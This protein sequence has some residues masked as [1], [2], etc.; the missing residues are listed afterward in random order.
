MLTNRR[1]I[2]A[3]PAVLASGALPGIARA[4]DTY[5]NRPVTVVV[6]FSAGGSTDL[7]A[8]L[9]AQ[10]LGDEMKQSF[11]VD[12]RAGA[13]GTLGHAMVARSK[14]DGY[15]LLLG[16]NSTYV[17]AP[18]LYNSIP[19]DSDTA[20]TPISLVGNNGQVLCVHPS[21]PAKDIAG[22]ITYLKAR[23]GQI[24]FSSSGV[25]GTSHMATE[26]FMSMSGTSMTHVPYRGGG[27]AAQALVAGEVGV[28]FVDIAT[29]GPL[30]ADKQ[31]RPLGISSLQRSS[32]M[33]EVPS[34]NDSLVG[35]E[36]STDFALLAPA[37]LPGAIQQQLYQALRKVLADPTLR[38]KMEQQG[39]NVIGSSPGEFNTYRA[40]EVARWGT[41]I[42]ERN[43]RAPT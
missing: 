12:N 8:R 21:L 27:P 42:R 7:V 23:P 4:A 40:R 17:M 37:G 19:Y 38:G 26:L 34:I 13:A 31:L 2:L 24:D 35:F 30:A 18:F 10:A 16:T 33:P 25:A 9:L 20:F 39:V 3:L 28:C 36:S 14:A 15:T 22:L 5:P 43:I 6:A 11:V 1:T 41:I 29:A 32:L